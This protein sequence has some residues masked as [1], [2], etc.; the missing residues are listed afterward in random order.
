MLSCDVEKD[1]RPRADRLIERLQNTCVSIGTGISR[2]GGGTMPKAEIPSLT[3]DVRPEKMSLKALARA[4]REGTPAVIAYTAED[5]LK[6]DLR[7]V[8]PDQ[9]DDLAENLLAIL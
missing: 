4:L 3:L 9:D 6:I 7:T 2:C 1:L 5:C 8:F